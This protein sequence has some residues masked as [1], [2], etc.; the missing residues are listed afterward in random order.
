V[1]DYG[2]L[3]QVILLCSVAW[4]LIRKFSITI[5]NRI[6]NAMTKIE[7]I[8]NAPAVNISEGKVKWA[9]MILGL[10]LDPVEQKAIVVLNERAMETYGDQEA[11]RLKW[12][13]MGGLCES[14]AANSTDSVNGVGA[15]STRAEIFAAF[16]VNA[17]VIVDLDRRILPEDSR[18]ANDK[19][20]V[21][22]GIVKR[23][24]AFFVS[25]ATAPVPAPV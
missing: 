21:C 14:L 2:A 9:A 11:N 6:M 1:H 8:V 10:T 5:G 15:S 7:P 18:S 3:Q 20:E 19:V 22:L 16:V 13:L 25:K 12:K 23:N 17:R 24:Q 4:L